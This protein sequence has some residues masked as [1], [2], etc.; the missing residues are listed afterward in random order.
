MQREFQ[1]KL[2][3]KH[4]FT[5]F[6]TINTFIGDI[7]ER[8]KLENYKEKNSSFIFI[9]QYKRQPSVNIM[10]RKILDTGDWIVVMFYSVRCCGEMESVKSC[11]L[12]SFFLIQ[13]EIP[14]IKMSSQMICNM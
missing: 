11:L 3:I 2:S 7:F 5:F 9:P 13:R 1:N 10:Q 4:A 14:F 8:K 6:A 12:F